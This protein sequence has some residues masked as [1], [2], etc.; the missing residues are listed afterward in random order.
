MEPQRYR[1]LLA[2]AASEFAAHGFEQASLNAVIRACGMSKS[3]FYHY[4]GSKEALF[5]RVVEEAATELARDLNAPDPETLAGPDFWDRIEAFVAAALAA[6]KGKDW[7][8]DLGRIFYLP[9][10]S[11]E[12]SAALQRVLAGVADWLGR[13]LAVGRACGAVRDD[14]PASLQA[15]LVFAVLQAMDRWS[16]HHM[17][18]FDD[19]ALAE[20]TRSQFAALRRLLSPNTP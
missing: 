1:Q 9:G 6:A 13:V 20:L 7:Y 18:D 8:A 19:K 5:D 12:Q 10:L 3:S 16:L 17:R 4:V 11:A 2:A 14:L 15:E